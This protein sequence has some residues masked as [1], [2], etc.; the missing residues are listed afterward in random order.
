MKLSEHQQEGHLKATP[1]RGKG[2]PKDEPNTKCKAVICGSL[3]KSRKH[4]FTDD[5][6]SSYVRAL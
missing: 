3:A 1:K 6:I 5:N 4:H 2:L